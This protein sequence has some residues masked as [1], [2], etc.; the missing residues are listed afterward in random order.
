M[1]LAILTVT[2]PGTVQRNLS[3]ATRSLRILAFVRVIKGTE[4]EGRRG[5]EVAEANATFFLPLPRDSFFP[6]SS[7]PTT[8][9]VCFE[10]VKMF[11]MSPG[12]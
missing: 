6:F 7:S 9:A 4:D 11:F 5:D 12:A 1:G 8:S 3:N 2:P 10:C